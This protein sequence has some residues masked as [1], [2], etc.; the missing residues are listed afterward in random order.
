MSLGLLPG[1]LCYLKKKKKVFPGDADVK[2]SS[3]EEWQ[4]A[5]QENV[6]RAK[7]NSA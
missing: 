4:D 3:E 2:S 6:L 7:V 1:T 5:M